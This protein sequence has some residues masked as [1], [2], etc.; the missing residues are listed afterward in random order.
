MNTLGSI[1]SFPYVDF[2]RLVDLQYFKKTASYKETLELLEMI[3][4][5][6][7]LDKNQ[8]ECKDVYLPYKD[9]DLEAVTIARD[10]F[11][12]KVIQIR[13]ETACSLVEERVE[14]PAL[15]HFIRLLGVSLIPKERTEERAFLQM[16]HYEVLALWEM[17]GCHT[18]EGFVVALQTR[19]EEFYEA[20]HK[21][22]K[23]S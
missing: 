5:K 11:C 23:D 3:G 6:K 15:N 22:L 17:I 8:K 14:F 2:Y 1:V 16:S 7:N 4:F 18:L 21:A 19:K 10:L 20:L 13:E 12:S 9:G